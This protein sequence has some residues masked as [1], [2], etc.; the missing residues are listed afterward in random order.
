M[1]WLCTIGVKHVFEII[2]EATH[3]VCMNVITQQSSYY[4]RCIMYPQLIS[5][6]VTKEEAYTTYMRNKQMKSW[7]ISR[8][9][10]LELK[11]TFCV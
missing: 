9:Q 4:I 3:T 10:R 7:I 6:Y 8:N 11:V 1:K 5:S 2:T